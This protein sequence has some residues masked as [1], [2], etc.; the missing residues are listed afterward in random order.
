MLM[1]FQNSSSTLKLGFFGRG[2]MR[3]LTPW[4]VPNRPRN[5]PHKDQDTAPLLTKIRFSPGELYF[6]SRILT[7]S[8]NSA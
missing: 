6:C 5:E 1:V 2:L 4:G 8:K 7:I 3:N